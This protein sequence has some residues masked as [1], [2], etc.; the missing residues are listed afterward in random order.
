[1]ISRIIMSAF[2]W[3][4]L[5]RLPGPIYYVYLIK[6][7][8]T[9]PEAWT[10]KSI[11]CPKAPGCVYISSATR[12]Q[13]RSTKENLRM[14]PRDIFGTGTW[15]RSLKS[16]LSI[17]IFNGKSVLQGPNLP[18]SQKCILGGRTL[19]MRTGLGGFKGLYSVRTFYDLLGCT[20]IR[21]TKY[22]SWPF[23]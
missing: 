15:V 17:G 21:S 13:L 4:G 8:K 11:Y 10:I 5:F 12:N 1:M 22:T 16:G 18:E 6:C 20:S 23:P 3:I 7:R 9:I 19:L 2:S 14:Y